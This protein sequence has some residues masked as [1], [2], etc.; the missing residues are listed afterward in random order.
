M[1]ARKTDE[2]ADG[3]ERKHT[4]GGSFVAIDS[5]L[6][7]VTDK[8]EGAF[9]S[10]PGNEGIIAQAWVN[11][12]G[13]MWVVAKCFWYSAG[14]T[15]RHEALMDAVVKQAR[16][17]GHPRMVSC[18]AN[19]SAEE[20]GRSLWYQNRHMCI[21]GGVSTCRAKRSNGEMIERTYDYVVACRSLKERI[22]AIEVVEEFESRP[23][24]AITV[25]LEGDKQI[26]EWREQ[27][28][29]RIYQ[30]SVG[31]LT[32]RM[33]TEEGEEAEDEE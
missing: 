33:K 11:V 13:G 4:S 26:Q 2:R 8:E 9:K 21:K 17:T 10:F 12:R 1:W 18:N 30:D 5:S 16:A 23:H 31:K 28:S 6:E 3:D 25:V 14:R 19:M 32:G 24:Q 20:F 27:K 22:K 7:A 15:P 29:R